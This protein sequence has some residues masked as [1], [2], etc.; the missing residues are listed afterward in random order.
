[1]SE[2]RMASFASAT[3]EQ[4][5]PQS[6][7]LEGVGA[8]TSRDGFARAPDNPAVRT[9]S[10][11]QRSRSASQRPFASRLS[12]LATQSL[13]I[14]G[15]IGAFFV[16]H[17]ML[18]PYWPD[19]LDGV[20][21]GRVAVLV[22]IAVIVFHAS[23]KL[24]P[25][26]RLHNYERFRRRAR[27]SFKV[28]A[29]AAFGAMLLPGGWTLALF[30]VAFLAFGL[31]VQPVTHWIA[32]RLCRRCGL[33]GER[34]FIFA[35]T[36]RSALLTEYFTRH[37]QYGLR[38][39][40]F[41]PSASAMPGG[42]GPVIAVVADDTAP[43]LEDLAAARRQFAE[44]ILLA[45]MPHFKI[46][47][48][49]PADIDGQ[50]GVRLALGDR[51]PASSAMRRALDL[52][53]AIPAA[54]LFAPFMLIAA[55]AIYSIDPGPVF[56]WQ[57]REGLAGKTIYV[58]KF[59]TMYRDAEQRLEALLADNPA[60]RAEWATHFKLKQDPRILP[61]AGHLLRSTSFDELP[62]LFNVIIGEMRIVGPRPFP[63]YHLLAMNA[64]FR[65]KRRSVTPGVT[66]LWQISE[67]SDADL[68]LQR[69][70]DE[71]YIDNQSLWFDWHILLNTLP[72]VFR[73]SGAY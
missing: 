62:Q 61:M 38:P 73:R 49:R 58:L 46:A 28:A 63:E 30:I 39:E 36:N 22:A 7:A 23:E 50:I 12:R 47:G 66:G 51:Q 52:A 71:F 1:M 37:W 40:P 2:F 67:R 17:L 3:M 20:E 42:N 72:A 48:L 53:I 55:A 32:L 25:G 19:R 11:A 27:A 10:A 26:Y 57:P 31:I 33:W 4:P 18:L 15:D 24:Y 45:D 9:E 41:P 59:R 13:L 68:D 16:A 43:L 65:H 6:A 69:Q 21:F 64:E 44:V 34:A 35:G 56:F 5:S 60:I 29:L 70:L 14:A 54:L 8:R